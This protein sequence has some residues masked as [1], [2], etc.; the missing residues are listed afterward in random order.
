M[1]AGLRVVEPAPSSSVA[2]WTALV[3]VTVKGDERSREKVKVE[4]KQ[5]A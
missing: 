4:M 2:S 5:G 3:E 1:P